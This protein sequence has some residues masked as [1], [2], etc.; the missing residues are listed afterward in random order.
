[1]LNTVIFFNLVYL[2]FMEYRLI[3]NKLIY[4]IMIPILI[5]K[6]FINVSMTWG[7]LKIEFVIL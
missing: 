7:L 4:G 3:F 6:E 1:M 5:F 2:S